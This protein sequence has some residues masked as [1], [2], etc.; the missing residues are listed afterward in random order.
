MEAEASEGE[1]R[2]KLLGEAVAAYR[3]A[4]EVHTR[5]ALPQDWAWSQ[6]NLARALRDQAKDAQSQERARL[7]REAIDAMSST[8]E[9]WTA[10]SR[11]D[12]HG[13]RKAWIAKAQVELRA[14]EKQGPR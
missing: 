5:E 14:L 6:N 7:L 12:R 8:L 3:S 9:V 13:P 10:E 11:P 2:A 4:L 1:E